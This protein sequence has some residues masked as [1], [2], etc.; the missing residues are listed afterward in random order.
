MNI[1]AAAFAPPELHLDRHS[2]VSFPRVNKLGYGSYF[3][4][5]LIAGI[6]LM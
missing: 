4:L 6:D 5:F 2:V 1:R 3:T